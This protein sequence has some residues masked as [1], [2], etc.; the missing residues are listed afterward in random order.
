MADS[1]RVA[2]RL[3]QFRPDFISMY[4]KKNKKKKKTR[5]IVINPRGLEKNW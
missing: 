4:V 3:I 1:A 2:P 5:E